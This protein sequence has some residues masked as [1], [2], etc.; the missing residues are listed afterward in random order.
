ME[1][2]AYERI[3]FANNL[4]PLLIKNECECCGETDTL[5]L[6]HDKQ[7]AQMLKETLDR[8]GYEYK[9]KKEDYTREQLENIT[10]MLLGVHIKSTYTTLC[11]KCHVEIHKNGEL[12]NHFLRKEKLN[13]IDIEDINN[14][15]K[16]LNSILNI[17]L[18]ANEQQKLSEFIINKLNTIGKN[19]DYR[20]KIIKPSTLKDIIKNVSKLNYNIFKSKE[21]KGIAK[22]R[23]YIIIS[24][25]IESEVL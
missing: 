23:R 19:I 20:T 10:D 13:I 3:K 1:L 17:K 25:I 21:T 24:K 22:G 12:I 15:E 11:E 4:R 14:L 16:Y 6:H 9:L 5:H 7:F 2:K 8:L 18:F